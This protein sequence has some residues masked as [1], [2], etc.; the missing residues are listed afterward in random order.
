MKPIRIVTLDVRSTEFEDPDGILRDRIE[1]HAL[2]VSV[3]L[4]TDG[5]PTFVRIDRIGEIRAELHRALDDLIDRLDFKRGWRYGSETVEEIV[6]RN[7]KPE[8]E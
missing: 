3:P 4:A 2:R 7:R 6:A 5:V 1:E 8:G